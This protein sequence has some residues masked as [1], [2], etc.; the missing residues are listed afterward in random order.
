MADRIS[1]GDQAPNFDLTSTEGSLLMLRD[2]VPRT[3][4]VLYFFS[5]PASE[6]TRRDLQALGA[7]KQDLKKLHAK[8]L[9]VSR[10]ELLSLQKLQAELKLPFPLLHDDRDF[11][12]LRPGGAGRGTGD[13]A[14]ALCG[15]PEPERAVA[16]EPGRR[17]RAGDARGAQVAPGPG[18]ADRELSAGG[19]QPPGRSM[20]ELVKWDVGSCACSGACSGRGSSRRDSSSRPTWRSTGSCAAAR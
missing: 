10:A 9:A 1:I 6:R 5:D 20:G 13:R 4:V 17:G 18:F 14:R 15:Q 2:E 8:A 11:G 16:V 19:D 12:P 3:A 7:K